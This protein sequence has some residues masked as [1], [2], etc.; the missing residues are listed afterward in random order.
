MCLGIPMQIKEILDDNLGRATLGDVEYTCDLSLIEDPKVGEYV[1]LHAGYAIER[2]D[3]K[4]ALETLAMF[5]E[6]EAAAADGG[7]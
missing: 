6:I 7:E 1:I 3:E 4:E 5:A 2:L